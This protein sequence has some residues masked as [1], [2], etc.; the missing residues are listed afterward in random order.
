MSDEIAK[1]AAYCIRVCQEHGRWF[2]LR[3][4]AIV[5]EGYKRAAD[6]GRFVVDVAAVLV[7]ESKK[8]ISAGG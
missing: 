5:T 8:G 1:A 4:I 2:P 6:K 7:E 3:N